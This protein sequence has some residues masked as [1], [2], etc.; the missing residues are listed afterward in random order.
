[1]QGLGLKSNLPS[2]AFLVDVP[3][4]LLLHGILFRNLRKEQTKDECH[5]QLPR[6]LLLVAG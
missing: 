5:G 1:M 4:G 6:Y 3:N 2:F